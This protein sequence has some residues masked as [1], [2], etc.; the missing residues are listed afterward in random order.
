MQRS[1]TAAIQAAEVRATGSSVVVP[2]GLA[3]QSAVSHNEQMDRDEDMI[4]LSSLLTVLNIYISFLSFHG[5][6]GGVTD[7]GFFV[8]MKD[9]TSKMPADKVATRQDAEGVMSGEVRNNPMLATQPGGVAASV[10]AA[11]RLNE[12]LTQ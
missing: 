7:R 5:S 10:A 9:A 6:V 3:A 4:K 1:D 12:N 8:E 2:G 11:A